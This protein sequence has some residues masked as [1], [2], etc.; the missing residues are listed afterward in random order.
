MECVG[1]M[2]S[3]ATLRR[4]F[5]GGGRYLFFN[6]ERFTK[7]ERSKKNRPSFCRRGEFHSSVYSEQIKCVDQ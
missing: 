4:G 1:L 7:G 6:N 2:P 5:F 3:S